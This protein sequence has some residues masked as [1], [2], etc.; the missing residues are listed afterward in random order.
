M[1]S[2][3]L[4]KFIIKIPQNIGKASY[5]Q[6]VEEEKAERNPHELAPEDSSGRFWCGAAARVPLPCPKLMLSSRSNN[7]INII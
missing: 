2:K 5:L 3:K 6:G 4:G 1:G 7:L